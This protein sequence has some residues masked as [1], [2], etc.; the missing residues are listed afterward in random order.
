MVVDLLNMKQQMDETITNFIE[1][2]RKLISKCMTQH[3]RVEYV[4]MVMS[5]MHPLLREILLTQ[6]CLDLNLLT[7][8]VFRIDQIITTKQQG[9][10]NWEMEPYMEVKV[11]ISLE[12]QP[13]VTTV[14][15]LKSW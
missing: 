13:I 4:N 15:Q 14:R 2:F 3:P 1:R 8:N 11:M 6:D 10:S 12:K 9:G 5:N 7:T